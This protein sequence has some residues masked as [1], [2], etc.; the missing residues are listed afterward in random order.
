MSGQTMKQSLGQ[1][2]IYF[3]I[4]PTFER[5]TTLRGTLVENVKKIKINPP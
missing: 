1:N 3:F 4:F 5:D 2:N